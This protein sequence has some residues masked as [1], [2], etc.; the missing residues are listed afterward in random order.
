MAFT[1]SYAV[2]SKLFLLFFTSSTSFVQRVAA[3]NKVANTHNIV[4]ASLEKKAEPSFS[5]KSSNIVFPEILKGSESEMLTYIEDFSE[6][7]RDYLVRMY[8]KGKDFL[9]KAST[10]LKKYDLPEEL[11]VLLA[12]ESEYSA[13]VVSRAGAVGYWQIMDVVALTYGMNYVSRGKKALNLKKHTNAYGDDRKNFGMATHTAAKYLRDSKKFV[14]DNWLLVVASYN[15]G[16]GNV[17]KAIRK[18]GKTNPDFWDI[19]K[20]LPAE[21]RAY[22]MNFITLNVIFNN[23]DLFA[24]EKLRFEPEKVILLG[25][26]M[27][28]IDR[29][30]E[31]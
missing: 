10:I 7:K 21:T 30:A 26:W 20:Y 23:Y 31:L 27:S 29:P 28:N 18:S 2:I 6:K 12:L 17:R 8:N 19:K 1:K 4:L 16:V 24:Q 22:V 11:G 9:P 5:V 3:Q 13:N 14:N 25:N 15:C